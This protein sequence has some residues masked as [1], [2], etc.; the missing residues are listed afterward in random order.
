MSRLKNDASD[1]AVIEGL[2]AATRREIEGFARK[3][4]ERH[5]VGV[6]RSEG[7]RDICHAAKV[8]GY[9]IGDISLIGGMLRR[10]VCVE[11]EFSRIRGRMGLICEDGK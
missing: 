3:Y 5:E 8:K 9:R 11:H 7:Q 2:W 6:R 1:F 4:A 10:D